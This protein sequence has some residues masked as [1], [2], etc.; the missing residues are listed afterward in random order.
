M[1]FIILGIAIVIILVTSFTFT[2]G[3]SNNNSN[4][5][6]W[7]IGMIADLHNKAREKK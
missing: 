7:T 3:S 2:S 5:D 6:W 4:I 1:F